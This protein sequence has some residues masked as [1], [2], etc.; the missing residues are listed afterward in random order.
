VVF[1]GLLSILGVIIC[2]IAAIVMAI[3]QNPLWKKWIF[4]FLSCFILLITA[5]L[6]SPSSPT[7]SNEKTE[8]Q[9][10]KVQE[11]QTAQQQK[12]EQQQTSYKA[13]YAG[14]ERQ[15]VFYDN[16][17]K[18]WKKVFDDLESGEIDSYTAYSKLKHID[19]LL[20]K[21]QNEFFEMKPPKELSDE[22]KKLLKDASDKMGTAASTR[23][24]AVQNA[25]EFIDNPKPS[26]QQKVLDNI[27]I[28]DSFA[29][30]AASQ[31]VRV[32]E[33]LQLPTP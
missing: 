27:K 23:R 1:L 24:D 16:V 33:E 28:S 12:I 10:E 29:L 22:Q 30:Q 20:R 6:N 11:E 25:M 21:N 14:M 4:G 7:I 18:G 15:L 3:K 9:Q 32:R 17:W 2:L 31:I 26:I 5:V 13:W 19:D 8:K